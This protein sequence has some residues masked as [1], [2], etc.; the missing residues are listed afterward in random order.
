MNNNQ[1]TMAMNLFLEELKK[2]FNIKKLTFRIQYVDH[3]KYQH[4][5]YYIFKYKKI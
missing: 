2:T 1:R 5:I 3:F 4:E